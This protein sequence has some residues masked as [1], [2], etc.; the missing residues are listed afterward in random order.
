MKQR[1]MQFAKRVTRTLTSEITAVNA[2]NIVLTASLHAHRV[3]ELGVVKALKEVEFKAFSQWGED[4]IIQYL[5][6]LVPIENETFIE[7]GVENY[8]E[9]NTRFLLMHDNWK[10]LV[11]DGS[12]K[13]IDQ[14]R[15]DE[16]YWKHELTAQ[17]RFINRDNI[18][19]I[20]KN[21]GFVGDIGLL[22]IDIDGNDYWVWEKIDVI[23]P[24]I[25]VC[26]YNST[27]GCKRP[28]TVPY[29][30]EFVRTDVHYSNLYYGASL[31]ALCHLAVRKGYDFVGSNSTGSNAF[32]VRND[33][34]HGL[35][36]F[37]AV[38]GY[39]ESKVRESRNKSGDLTFLTGAERLRLIK[40]MP[41][42][43][44]DNDV[45]VP[46]KDIV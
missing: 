33:L 41:V 6:N 24:R 40:D 32:F 5:I 44:I 12:Q 36:K 30:A 11:V 18:N 13:H 22:S 7:F 38:D 28:I 29:N 14:I 15:N 9:A 31:A 20:F 4:G 23:M 46:I 42:Y 19:E 25:V 3:K 43:D 39:I 37:S 26:E 16:I 17:C 35:R 2:T 21:A 8:T 45:I 1:I 10:G 27:F 34:R